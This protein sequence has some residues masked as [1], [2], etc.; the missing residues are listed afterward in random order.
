[1]SPKV[2]VVI[3]NWNGRRYLED[4]LTSL[5]AQTFTDF[6]IILVDNGSTDGSVE[7]VAECFPQV[8][9]IRNETNVGFAAGNNQAIS[10]SQAEFVAT[11]NND[12][13]VEPDWLAVLIAAAEEEPTVGMCASKM[14][15]ADRP[16]IINSTGINLDP[17]GIAWDRQGG[18]PDD[19]QETEPVEVF[20]PCA[21]AALYRRTMLDRIGMFDEDF[22]AYLEDVDLAW[23]ARMAGWRCLY[24]PSARVYHI[25]SATGG[26]G[27]PFKNRLLGRNKVWTIAKN[28]PT[29]RLVLYLPLILLYDLAAV[30]Y[31]LVVRRDVS[32]LQGR[33]D[34]L[35]GLPSVW[36]QRQR[37]QMLRRESRG[38]PWHRYLS[39]LVPLWRVPARYR[40]L[41]AKETA[42]W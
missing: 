41:R 6:E 32:S 19:R 17:I 1:M 36:R 12:T 10:A 35:R 9:V 24:V 37:I 21:G 23:R 14:L 30:L 28:Y 8:R 7:W 15:F 27:S 5:Q 38:Q 26:E 13:R 4:C 25:H 11:L 18:E 40:H 16:G 22:F 2:S 42:D 29:S 31:T 20:G 3:L 39:P 34:G 33:L